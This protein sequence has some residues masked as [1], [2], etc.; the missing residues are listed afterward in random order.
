MSIRIENVPPRRNVSDEWRNGADIPL[1]P[2]PP[3]PSSVRVKLSASISTAWAEF[4]DM[5]QGPLDNTSGVA[6]K[7]WEFLTRP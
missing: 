6:E 2:S 7:F 3:M 1:P 5:Y 4:I